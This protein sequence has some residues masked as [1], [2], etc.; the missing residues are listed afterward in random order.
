MAQSVE[1]LTLNQW[2]GGSSPPGCTSNITRSSARSCGFSALRIELRITGKSGFCQACRTGPGESIFNRESYGRLR[3][4]RGCMRG[5]S[6]SKVR[7][8][9]C[10]TPL[11]CFATGSSKSQSRMRTTYK[12]PVGRGMVH[13]K[14][15]KGNMRYAAVFL[16]RQP[17][18][19]VYCG[20]HGV[21]GS[22]HFSS[23]FP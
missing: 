21:K 12:A 4:A 20:T 22:G 23:A 17:R 3:G 14:G 7:L 10:M 6:A 16:L 1:Q 18:E 15:K 9:G 11:E 2:V 19:G 5:L 8:N 13:R